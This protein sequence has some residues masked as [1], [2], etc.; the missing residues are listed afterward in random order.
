MVRKKF[1]FIFLLG[2]ITSGAFQSFVYA[3][4]AI[5]PYQAKGAKHYI[6]ENDCMSN[7]DMDEV[8]ADKEYYP[9]VAENTYLLYKYYWCRGILDDQVISKNPKSMEFEQMDGYLYKR[10]NSYKL[11]TLALVSEHAF[12]PRLIKYCD[13]DLFSL[14]GCRS[15]IKAFWEKDTSYC[16]ENEACKAVITLNAN[17]PALTGGPDKDKVLYLS[18]LNNFDIKK[19]GQIKDKLLART[20]KAYLNGDG[21]ICEGYED[22]AKFKKTYCKKIIESEK[23]K[24]EKAREIKEGAGKAESMQ[25]TK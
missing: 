20:C 2:V 25:Q 16:K 18:A 21:K 11:L 23:V 8:L 6:D 9:F 1:I 14:D 5:Q 22:F 17:S 13:K 4:D 15:F 10:F 24:E 7:F 12:S 19:C 3:E